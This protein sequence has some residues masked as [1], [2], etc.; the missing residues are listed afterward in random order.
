MNKFEL[1]GCLF[2]S[3]YVI[4]KKV[5]ILLGIDFDERMNDILIKYF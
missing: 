3:L 2:C 4:V 5:G 1:Y